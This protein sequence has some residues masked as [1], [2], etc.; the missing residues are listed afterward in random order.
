MDLQALPLNVRTKMLDDGNYEIWGTRTVNGEMTEYVVKPGSDADRA[1]QIAG[2]LDAAAA[3]NAT[4]AA[5]AAPTVAQNTAQV[6]AL[7]R[8]VDALIRRML[9]K[10][11]KVI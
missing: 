2:R 5:L 6:Q 7:T 4:Y 8:Q 9:A 3:A 11:D 10:F 1:A